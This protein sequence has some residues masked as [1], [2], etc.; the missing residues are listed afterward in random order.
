VYVCNGK[1]CKI[2]K[3]ILQESQLIALAGQMSWDGASI[4]WRYGRGFWQKD[5]V[6]L[7]AGVP[8]SMENFK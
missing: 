4:I 8:L 7:G 3:E 2:K 5:R 1:Y 6:S